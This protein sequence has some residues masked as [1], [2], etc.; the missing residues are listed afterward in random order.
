MWR[1][2]EPVVSFY[3]LARHR[4]QR[5][6]VDNHWP[7]LAYTKC[8]AITRLGDRSMV[9]AVVTRFLQNVVP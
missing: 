4:H 6:S 3:L 5:F 2:M 7:L 1:E 9:N 8:E